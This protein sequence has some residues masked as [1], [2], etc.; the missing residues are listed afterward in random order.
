[1]QPQDVAVG[2]APEHRLRLVIVHPSAVSIVAGATQGVRVRAVSEPRA[3]L[4]EPDPELDVAEPAQAGV[5]P[6]RPLEH[7]PAHREVGGLRAERDDDALRLA[8]APASQ[9]A[10]DRAEDRSSVQAGSRSREQRVDRRADRLVDRLCLGAWLLE[11]PARAGHHVGTAG[12][13]ALVGDQ[14]AGPHPHIEIEEHHDVAG[15]GAPAELAAARLAGEA[16]L[17][18]HAHRQLA[19][20]RGDELIDL[21]G[22]A[23]VDD[24]DLE[25]AGRPLEARQRAQQPLE[26]RARSAGRDDDRERSTH[27]GGSS[28]VTRARPR[29]RAPGH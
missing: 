7:V 12:Q 20:V 5:E 19:R 10:L 28:P 8:L 15:G 25:P 2:V 13:R 21:I 29:A 6:G 26:V 24:H 16:S 3:V 4:P 18:E 22:R 27:G 14:P 11:P 1:V 23:I 9:L 17:R